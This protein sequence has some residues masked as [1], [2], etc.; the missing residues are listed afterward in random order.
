MNIDQCIHERRSVRAFTAKYLS[1]DTLS[2]ILDAA[3]YAPSSGN[4][5]NWRFIIIREKKNK[6]TLTQHC[7]KENKWAAKAS[8]LIIVCSDIE[9]VKRLYGVRGEALYAIQNCAAA[10]QTMLLKAHSL[11]VAGGWIGDFDEQAIHTTFNLEKNVRPQAVLAF[12]YG[13]EE[14]MPARE[15]LENLVFFEK[16]GKREA[17]AGRKGSLPFAQSIE[18]ELEKLKERLHGLIKKD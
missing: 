8:I 18:H 2:E 9:D 5:Q 15:P 13:K 17:P 14:D 4:V 7:G 16:Y 3:R 6:E 10:I 12:G 11:G 1:D